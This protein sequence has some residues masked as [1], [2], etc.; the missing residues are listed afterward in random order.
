MYRG[1]VSNQV[2]S[3]PQIN[4]MDLDADGHISIDAFLWT[5][6]FGVYLGA[7]RIMASYD[8]YRGA[9]SRHDWARLAIADSVF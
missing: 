8:S 1:L 9:R 6:K 2:E 3:T 7:F 5:P 4:C